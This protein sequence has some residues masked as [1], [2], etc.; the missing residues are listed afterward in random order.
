VQVVYRYARVLA[1]AARSVAYNTRALGI[2]GDAAAFDLAAKGAAA[3][4]DD[5]TKE[6]HALRVR[7]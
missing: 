5:V 1:V 7:P 2:T 4:Q 3:R 6:M